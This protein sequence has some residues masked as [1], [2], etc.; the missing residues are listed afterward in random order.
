MILTA[1]SPV[2]LVLLDVGLPDGNGVTVCEQ[3]KK[4]RET[5]PV[6]LVS[7]IYRTADVRRKGRNAGADAYL[8]EPISARRLV[9]TVLSLTDPDNASM[10]SWATVRTTAGARILWLDDVA[11]GLLNIKD[12]GARGRDLLEVPLQRVHARPVTRE[13]PRSLTTLAVSL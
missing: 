9:E 4:A 2:D 12:R 11:A 10:P 7:A 1:A 6:V 5:L 3:I 8:V 13:D